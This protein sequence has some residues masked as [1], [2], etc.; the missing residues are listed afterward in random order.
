MELK[1]QIAGLKAEAEAMKRTSEA[2]LKVQLLKKEQKIRKMEAM[3]KVYAESVA[4]SSRKEDQPIKRTH[5]QEGK[6]KQRKQ[7]KNP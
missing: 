1:A 7:K 4:C 5:H 3:E 6:V 2:E